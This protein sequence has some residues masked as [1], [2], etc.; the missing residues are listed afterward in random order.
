VLAR[1]DGHEIQTLLRA[2][3]VGGRDLE[4]LARAIHFLR[5]DQLF[6][7]QVVD[8]AEIALGPLAGGLR[9]A[10]VGSRLF[11]LLL[12]RAREQIL[13][14]RLGARDARFRLLDLLAPGAG[15]Q[16]PKL[17]LG[18]DVRA[19]GAARFR[20][21]LFSRQARDHDAALDGLAF[22]HR[23]LGDPAHH[24]GA[25]V[26]LEPLDGA[27]ERERLRRSEVDV[28]PGARQ[29]EHGEDDRGRAER[30]DARRHGRGRRMPTFFW[31]SEKYAR[32]TRCTS[33][34]VTARMLL[35]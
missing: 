12:A 11:D 8:A 29:H 35:R 26:D 6:S 18:G 5:G 10:E 23:E 9:V 22:A 21:Q 27:R 1:T 24:P 33:A 34:A 7:E 32:A 30:S 19:L 31:A 4:R 25:H 20:G 16:V 3:L 15:H 14:L 28:R 13:K 17:R 2:G